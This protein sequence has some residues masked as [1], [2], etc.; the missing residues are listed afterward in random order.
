MFVVYLKFK[1]NWISCI[2]PGNPTPGSIH[3]FPEGTVNQ[4]GKREGK[5]AEVGEGERKEGEKEEEGKREG[6]LSS[7][8]EGQGLGLEESE[9][10]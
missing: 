7:G 8:L 1:F 4:E 6:L 10:D 3:S 5:K 2:L 9:A